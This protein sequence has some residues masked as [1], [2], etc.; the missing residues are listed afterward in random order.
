MIQYQ[1]PN[2]FVLE[3]SATTQVLAGSFND[4]GNEYIGYD[5][6]KTL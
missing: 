3:I 1:S 6:E 4:N 2:C 5:G